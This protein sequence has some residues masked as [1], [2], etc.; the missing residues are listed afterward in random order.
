[1]LND[2]AALTPPFV[3]C[4]AV[5]IGVGAF[6]RHEMR[7]NKGQADDD[8]PAAGISTQV[9]DGQEHANDDANDRASGRGDDSS[10]DRK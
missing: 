10:P 3:V 4:V 6:L 7:G 1:M 5:L 2:L 8:D 9:S